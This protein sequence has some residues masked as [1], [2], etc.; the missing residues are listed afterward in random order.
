MS[1]NQVEERMFFTDVLP[2]WRW[3]RF[4]KGFDSLKETV[5]VWWDDIECVVP[6]LLP[7]HAERDA[8]RQLSRDGCYI[9]VGGRYTPTLTASEWAKRER[10]VNYRYGISAY[11]SFE[12]GTFE[13]AFAHTITGRAFQKELDKVVRWLRKHEREYEPPET[14]LANAVGSLADWV[15]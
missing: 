7:E 15:Q 4:E 11:W 10:R 1:W 14:A 13:F 12:R 5:S 9:Y 3:D 6:M 2:T 8:R